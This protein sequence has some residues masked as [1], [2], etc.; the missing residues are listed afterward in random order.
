MSSTG[1]LVF[2]SLMSQAQLSQVTMV[3]FLRQLENRCCKYYR[4]TTDTMIS[5]QFTLMV[6]I[7]LVNE[8][9]HDSPY[10]L[11]SSSWK[12]IRSSRKTPT[13]PYISCCES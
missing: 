10:I 9:K 7:E 1:V 13:E 11:L 5:N 2:T 6:Q 8:F 12:P 4:Y 3:F